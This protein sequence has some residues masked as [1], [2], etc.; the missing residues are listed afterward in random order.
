MFRFVIILLASVSFM[1]CGP[2]VNVQYDTKTDFSK[3]QTYY[4]YPAIASGLDAFEDAI[5]V[6]AIDS[7][8]Q[9]RNFKL[10]RAADFLVNYYVNESYESF[11]HLGAD[12]Y[13]TGTAVQEFVLDF[14]DEE[15]DE[16]IWQGRITGKISDGITD[17]QLE[18]YYERIISEL[19]KIYPP[20]K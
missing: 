1:S 3:Y 9:Q 17:K 10:D 2:L 11:D 5:V 14:V 20:K 6:R 13:N 7:L 19:L 15:K 12:Y 16:L 18:R 8:L 4:F